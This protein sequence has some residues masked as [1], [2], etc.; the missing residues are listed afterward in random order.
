MLNLKPPRHTPT[1]P[2]TSPP[3][4]VGSRSARSKHASRFDRQDQRESRPSSGGAGDDLVGGGKGGAIV[5]GFGGGPGMT[6]AFQNPGARSPHPALRA[7]LGSSPTRFTQVELQRGPP[8]PA[9][10]GKV[11]R[12]AGWVRPTPSNQAGLRDCHREPSSGHPAFRTPSG[13]PGHPRSSPLPRSHGELRVKGLSA[14]ANPLCEARRP[15]GARPFGTMV[16]TTPRRRG[17][18]TRR[19]AA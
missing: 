6:G 17:A 19:A 16:R 18:V 7:T 10:L 8:S 5:E 1:L 13:P 15:N 14:E 11:A 9:L 12:S 3:C 4:A 2:T